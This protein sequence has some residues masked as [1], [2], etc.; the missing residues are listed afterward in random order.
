[1]QEYRY[2]IRTHTYKCTKYETWVKSEPNDEIR[3]KRN[4]IEQPFSKYNLWCVAYGRLLYLF[5]YIQDIVVQPFYQRFTAIGLY[6]YNVIPVF[7][8]FICTQKA[9]LFQSL[10]SKRKGKLFMLQK[11]EKKNC[12]SSKIVCVSTPVVRS[13]ARSAAS[14]GHCEHVKCAWKTRL[15]RNVLVTHTYLNTH[16]I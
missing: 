3:A 4:N 5:W 10:W 9:S 2:I 13:Y 8:H 7:F 1:M 12:N 15:I 16:V 11:S 6:T 14:I